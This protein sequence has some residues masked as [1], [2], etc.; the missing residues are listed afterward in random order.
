MPV[1]GINSAITWVEQIWH[2]GESIH[3]L[4]RRH[5]FLACLNNCFISPTLLK[6]LDSH[7]PCWQSLAGSWKLVQK[8]CMPHTVQRLRFPAMLF[9]LK[10]H[11]KTRLQLWNHYLLTICKLWSIYLYVTG[12]NSCIYWRCKDSYTTLI[13]VIS[14]KICP[15]PWNPV[16]LWSIQENQEIQRPL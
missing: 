16:L 13:S 3:I 8:M 5:T 6:T 12:T 15:N 1:Q 11:F 9:I 4:S 2:H 10:A 7:S 14:N